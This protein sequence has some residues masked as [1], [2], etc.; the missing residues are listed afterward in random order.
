LKEYTAHEDWQYVVLLVAI[1]NHH[2]SALFNWNAI[3]LSVCL[4]TCITRAPIGQ[5]YVEFDIGD[6]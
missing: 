6:R 3:M 4:S 1:L 2:R 5:F